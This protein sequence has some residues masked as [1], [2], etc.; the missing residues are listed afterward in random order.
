M[1]EFSMRE[2]AR[3]SGYHPD[4]VRNFAYNN[5][6]HKQTKRDILNA[7]YEKVFLMLVEI[8]E[9]EERGL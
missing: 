6:G 1:K 4:T 9:L 2:V 3:L 8:K 7:M 5:R